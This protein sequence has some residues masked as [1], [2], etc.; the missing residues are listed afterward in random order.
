MKKLST[1]LL[2]CVMIIS[3]A[4]VVS[5]YWEPEEAFGEVKFTIGKQTTAWNADGQISDGEYY[6]VEL[7]PSW[8]S[9]AINDN[10]TDAGLEYAKATH[11]ELYMS[12][13]E[14]YIY[15]ATRY[16]VTK[17]HEN[18]W[19][20]DPASMWYS[21][22][23]QFNYANFD[24]VASEYRLE[25]GVGLSSDTGNL[26]YTVWADGAG[27]GFTPSEENAKVWLDGNTLT[28]ETRVAWEDFADEDNTA[29]KE[30][31]G[32]NF[33]IVWSIG[34]GQDYV[35][36]QLAE[37]CTGNGKHAENF[38]QVTLGP[39][40]ASAV[41]VLH[42]TP[43][44]DGKLD[45]AYL[46]SG[47]L[48]LE[49]PG[50]YVWDGDEEQDETATVYYLWDEQNLYVIGV[51]KDNDVLDVGAE[52]YEDQW[53][54]WQA[55]AVENWFNVGE[56]KWKTHA[57]AYGH[58][59]YAKD[60]GGGSEPPFDFEEVKYAAALTDD[61]YIVEYALPI[62][63]LGVGAF[64]ST[65]VQVNDQCTLD[66]L[67][68]TGYASGSQ[69]ADHPLDLVADEAASSS[70]AAAEGKTV[71]IP[72]IREGGVLIDAERDAAY[73]ACEPQAMVEQN[74]DY[75]SSS[76]EDSTGTFWA[77]YDSD[78]I[79][80]YVDVA[81]EDIDYSNENP[82]ET[83]N[84]ESIGVMFDFSYNRTKDYEYS[85]S[86]NGDKVCYVNLSGDGVLVTYHMY[87]KELTNGL[88][89][90]IEYKTVSD[91]GSGHILY[92]IACPIP[93]EVEIEEGGR[94][95][96]E[97]IATE[98]LG[99]TR[100]G[101]VSWSPAGSEMWH[102]SDVLGTAYWGEATADAAISYPASGTDGNAVKG[103]VIGNATGW[104]DNAA[105]GAAAALDGDPATFFDPL[106][107]GDG[108]CG[109]DAGESYILDKV[110]VLSRDGFNDRFVGAM[111]Q[112]SNDGE[113][114]TTL[115]TSDAE[116]TYPDYYTVTEFENNTGYS[117]FRY[118]NE[119]NHGD[120]AEVEFYGQPG[121]VEETPAEEA[122]AAEAPAEETPAEAPVDQ[123][124]D[125]KAEAPNTF[126]F[127]ILAAVASMVS[128]GGFALT[129]KKH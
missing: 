62:P 3:L 12:W 22:A 36:I 124:L 92:E 93:D 65:S 104:G 40:P 4:V 78:F 30:G 45:D 109:I 82:E 67:Y 6:K 5:A 57:D 95:G 79:Y 7:D 97:V 86:G 29:G 114:W 47:S 119:T 106:G 32:F 83:W 33:C 74:L 1:V 105:A 43:E 70:G 58:T 115:W 16:E 66:D 53:D 75:F 96:L 26:L 15:T 38:A 102:Y 111:I 76:L 69:N 25:Y 35:H 120:V 63:G 51:V 113:N 110:V 28:Y 122:P 24:E 91:N 94:F 88:Y 108:F 118:Y 20:A 125:Q 123:A 87:D 64:V 128:L 44:I 100:Q 71:T 60:N 107:V 90:D 99:G 89:N 117:Q 101:C 46:Q 23:V 37:G 68:G 112:G 55:D 85:Y 10:D 73:D 21:G 127:G 52:R 48:E 56:G 13:D 50:F 8:I 54:N 81:D 42:G 61:G 84:R 39:A 98:A 27:T 49:N 77:A 9:Y 126:D 59:F 41:T 103:T 17:G 34:E 116:G 129:R 18:L 11:P 80:L 31:L 2:A 72:R 14:N 19:D 121:K